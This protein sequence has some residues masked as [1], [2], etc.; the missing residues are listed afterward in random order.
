MGASLPLE[1]NVHLGQLSP[2]TSIHVFEGKGRVEEYVG[3]FD[4][5]A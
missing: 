3:G 5:R 2:S 4:A 1:R